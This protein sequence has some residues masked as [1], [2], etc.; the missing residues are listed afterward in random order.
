M[1]GIAGFVDFSKTR[2]EDNLLQEIK[3]M[4]NAIAYRGPDGEGHWVDAQEGVA[5]GHRRLAIL[6]L[7][8]AGFQPMRSKNER[9]VLTYN[10]EIYNSPDL[11]E[12]LLT[13]GY[14]FHG[15][16]DTE[17]MLAAFCEWGIAES[18]K[19][20]VGMFAFALWDRQEKT[21]CLGRDR[22]GK[23]PLYYGWIDSLFV[24]A[25]DLN[26]FRA[27]PA[28]SALKIDR[29]AMASFHHWSFLPSPYSLYQGVYKLKP[30]T[31]R[32]FGPAD[33]ASFRMGA[34]ECF[35][36]FT[37]VAKEGLKRRHSAPSF[38]EAVEQI[39]DLLKDAVKSRMMSD[40]PLGGFL[41]GGIDSSLIIA[42]MQKYSSNPVKTFSVGFAESRYDESSYA[43]KVANYLG[44]DHQTIRM[45]SSDALEIIPNLPQIYDEPFAD[46]SQLP[47]IL[48]SRLAG[49]SVKVVLSGDG[50]DEIFAGYTRYL[51]S[52][53]I[54]K[55][56][57]WI[58]L[59][60]RQIMITILRSIPHKVWQVIEPVVFIKQLEEKIVKALPLLKENRFE[61]LYEGLLK[62]WN[63]Y[64]GLFKEITSYS[65]KIS[66]P[67]DQ[68]ANHIDWMQYHDTLQYLVDDILVKVDR[69]TMAVSLEARC[70]LLDHRLLEQAWA[71]PLSYK[72]QEGKGKLLLRKIL[73]RYI[74]EEF[75]ER[76]KMGFGI[77]IDSWLRGPLKE[78]ADHLLLPEVLEERG[79]RSDIIHQQ[80]K[81]H[82]EEGTQG[83]DQLWMVL[84]A[85][86]WE[87]TWGKPL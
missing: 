7:S 54:N 34:E 43:E 80:W 9:F 73:S 87:N 70:P 19:K 58:P 25:S 2:K 1:C 51:M 11:K 76:P 59:P 38:L 13:K 5:L 17:V 53:K 79:Y 69:A 49:K 31:L 56:L 78:W 82:C 64:P 62:R 36:D 32:V 44:T 48:V 83:G 24:F 6:D 77:P 16:S 26:A 18:L 4:T 74:P 41:S 47:T 42:L 22:I 81:A 35:W 27:S 40:V 66:N 57:K 60:F 20:M 37:E 52:E 28:K 23:K 50:G 12:T 14:S 65:L 63:H 67:F 8:P 21:L 15:H 72:I 30:G 75:F 33:F 84:M 10:G 46:T 85:Q 55:V 86:L 71:L 3:A 45:S 29:K 68:T 39:E 61:D